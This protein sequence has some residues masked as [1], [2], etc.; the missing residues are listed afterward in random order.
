MRAEREDQEELVSPIQI[1]PDVSGDRMQR[2]GQGAKSEERKVEKQ[3]EGQDGERKEGEGQDGG[4]KENA[5]EEGNDD[6]LTVALSG[7]VASVGGELY[8]IGGAEGDM[9]EK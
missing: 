8:E 3:G 2:E 9:M 5:G 1:Q 6:P 4:Q 7:T